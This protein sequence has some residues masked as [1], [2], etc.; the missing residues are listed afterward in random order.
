MSYEDKILDFLAK[1]E[2]LPIA[3]QIAEYVQKLKETTHQRFWPMFSE[4]MSE[5]LGASTYGEDWSFVPPPPER[6]E[7]SYENCYLRPTQSQYPNQPVLNVAIQQGS[8]NNN[9]RLL[10]G[11][12]WTPEP[13]KESVS[14][15]FEV[16]VERLIEMNRTHS[17]DKWPGWNWLHHRARGEQFV[18]KM[19]NEPEGLMDELSE[20]YWDF[21]LAIHPFIND[22]MQKSVE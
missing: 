12:I 7:K 13:P 21:F 2:N 11:V 6:W 15:S 18:M 17:S 9:F 19:H 3:F 1:S 16:L 22:V 20:M 4:F 10:M 5:R 8:P 14:K